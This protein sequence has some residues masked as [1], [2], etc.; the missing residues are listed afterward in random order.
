M[1]LKVFGGMLGLYFLLGGCAVEAERQKV[2]EPADNSETGI[3]RS[4]SNREMNPMVAEKD[5][6]KPVR[7]NTAFACDLYAQLKDGD[8]N[9]VFSPLSISPA[10]A[11]TWAGAEGETATET[12]NALSFSLPP[13]LF[14]IQDTKTET[15]L[16]MERVL[17]PVG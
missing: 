1:N 9:I 3:V 10:V 7:G 11:M 14:F 8:D 13:F 2:V 15:I 12:A 16:F 5:L 6:E 4:E 17:N